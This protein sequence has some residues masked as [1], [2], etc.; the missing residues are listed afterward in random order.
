MGN[1]SQ[2]GCCLVAVAI[3]FIMLTGCAANKDNI[4]KPSN[5]NPYKTNISMNRRA[6]PVKR[7]KR[8]GYKCM[9]MKERE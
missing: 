8:P 7:E 5:A 9:R 1:N 6:C 4:E 3:I 2:Y